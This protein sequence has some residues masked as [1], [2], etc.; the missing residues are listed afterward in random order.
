MDFGN[1]RLKVLISDTLHH[2]DYQ[3][4][5]VHNLEQALAGV[6]N[7]C[8][9]YYSSVNIPKSESVKRVLSD[10][11]FISIESLLPINKHIDLSHVQGM[12][13]D[14]ILG[15]LGAL[16]EFPPPFVTIDCGTMITL[17]ILSQSF[18][19]LGGIILPGFNTMAKA[20]H[21]FTSAL[22]LIHVFDKS[23][24]YGKNT[25]AALQTGIVN[26][27]I[28]GIERSLQH[29]Y[30][31]ETLPS[32]SPIIMTGGDGHFLYNTLMPKLKN[33][34]YREQLIINGMKFCA[35]ATLKQGND[36]DDSTTR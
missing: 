7:T 24:I 30:D 9:I 20:A 36:T 19:L 17:N 21:N 27:C 14:R 18:T 23:E 13:T 33:V 2:F 25:N 22:P 32:H 26:A 10:Y 5:F 8:S 12:G 1:T 31:S 28:G 11:T 34:Y 3:E 29:L 16:L 15:V 6:Q 4:Q 35:E